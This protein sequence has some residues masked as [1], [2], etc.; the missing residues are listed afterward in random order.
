MSRNL[1]LQDEHALAEQS[2][3]LTPPCSLKHEPCGLVYISRKKLLSDQVS[4][5][6]KTVLSAQEAANQA[7][8]LRDSISGH[9][10]GLRECLEGKKDNILKKWKGWKES[11]RRST[12]SNACPYLGS[13]RFVQDV[14]LG[15]FKTIAAEFRTQLMLFPLAGEALSEDYR[16]L[17]GL[18]HWRVSTKPED[19][20][21]F[22]W[23]QLHRGLHLNALGTVFA[24]GC[25]TMFGADFG[26]LRPFDEVD[27]HCSDAFPTAAALLVL[28]RQSMIYECLHEILLPMTESIVEPKGSSEWDALAARHFRKCEDVETLFQHIDGIFLSPVPDI[29]E[30]ST[31]VRGRKEYF[32]D[33]LISLSTDVEYFVCLCAELQAMRSTDP[34]PKHEQP[35][36]A[37]ETGVTL[38][39]FQDLL[40]WHFINEALENLVVVIQYHK[41]DL[42]QGQARSV[43][44]QDGLSKLKSLATDMLV[45]TLDD[46]QAFYSCSSVFVDQVTNARR[47]PDTALMSSSPPWK[48]L[49]FRSEEKLYRADPLLSMFARLCYDL[50]N[51]PFILPELNRLLLKRE[52]VKRVNNRMMQAISEIGDLWRVIEFCGYQCPQVSKSQQSSLEQNSCLAVHYFAALRQGGVSPD[53]FL[54]GRLEGQFKG[55]KVARSASGENKARLA[56]IQ[57]YQRQLAKGVQLARGLFLAMLVGGGLQR[58]EDV[59][60]IEDLLTPST[61]K[62]SAPGLHNNRSSNFCPGL[63]ATAIAKTYVPIPQEPEDVFKKSKIHPA[64]DVVDKTVTPPAAAEPYHPVEPPAVEIYRLPARLYRLIDH[65]FPTGYQPQGQVT[66]QDF[67]RF[68]TA[69]GFGQNALGGSEYRFSKAGNDVRRELSIVIHKR[70]PHPAYI[71]NDLRRMGRRL[72]DRFAWTAD[73]FKPISETAAERDLEIIKEVKSKEEW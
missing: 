59:L 71:A 27:V 3:P 50:N 38:S 40:C 45:T 63:K 4:R 73:R 55:L 21:A 32:E 2:T 41:N 31:L 8:V 70:H 61:A 67:G 54:K 56:A 48:V 10:A 24:P 52:Q 43:E 28:E 1:F 9:H 22:D 64:A 47:R 58:H 12:I 16:T 25:I 60:Y 42:R 14:L 20:V 51:I 37:I 66:F 17:L 44:Y 11:R 26:Q 30:I 33:E 39:A 13:R 36:E 5:E 18:A 49:G 29:D 19:C 46:L 34:R 35:L 53:L 72:S 6:Y 68:M 23:E 62:L 7:A 15:K 69:L 65:L 57:E